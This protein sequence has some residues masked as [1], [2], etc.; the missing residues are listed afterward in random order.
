MVLISYAIKNAR[1]NSYELRYL[2]KPYRSLH[3]NYLHIV[4]DILDI[5]YPTV[6]AWFC[7]ALDSATEAAIT[8]KLGALS[9]DLVHKLATHIEDRTE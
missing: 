6:L 2:R 5:F 3:V 1:I 9:P 7:T 8:T 4:A